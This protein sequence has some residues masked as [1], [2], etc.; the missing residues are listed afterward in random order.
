MQ[1][2]DPR[3]AELLRQAQQRVLA[4]RQ[5]NSENQ[6]TASEAGKVTGSSEAEGDTDGKPSW[7]HKLESALARRRNQNAKDGE[8]EKA[9][10]DDLQ[11]VAPLKFVIT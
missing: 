2:L 8:G 1:D 3:K 4:K 7:Q 10:I 6:P 9:W 11:C 5:K